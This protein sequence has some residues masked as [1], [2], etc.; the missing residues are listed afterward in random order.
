MK[1][2]AKIAKFILLMLAV[3][4]ASVAQANV[5]SGKLWHV[6]EAITGNATQANVPETTPDVTFD[7]NSPLNFFGNGATVSAWLGSGGAFNVAENTTGTL[8]SLMDN[9]IDGT[10]I[11]FTGFVTALNGQTFTVTHD[12]GLT[13]IIGGVDLGFDAT[14]P[15]SSNSV[16]STATYTGVSGNFAFDLIYTC[17]GN[18]SVL[19]IGLPLAGDPNPVPEPGT[20]ALVGIALAG[21][22]WRRRRQHAH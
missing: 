16:I 10:L 3:A 9:G 17:C 5:I 11:Y 7:V 4:G 6:A 15:A 13:L 1:I 2:I 22:G 12:S 20:L 19:Q 14:P 21:F 18:A 8:A